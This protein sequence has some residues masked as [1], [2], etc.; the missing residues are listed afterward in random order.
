[1]LII[2]TDSEVDKPS[3]MTP[4]RYKIAQRVYLS[5]FRG[6]FFRD[7]EPLIDSLIL[8]KCAVDCVYLFKRRGNSSTRRRIKIIT[9]SQ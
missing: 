7:P 5:T 2:I 1:M 6:H 3:L 8:I 9:V 4:R